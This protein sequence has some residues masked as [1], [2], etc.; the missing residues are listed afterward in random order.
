[1]AWTSA[2]GVGP[3]HLLGV[4]GGGGGWFGRWAPRGVGSEDQDLPPPR[5]FFQPLWRPP[6]RQKQVA[7]PTNT[8]YTDTNMEPP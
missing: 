6:S 5:F 8:E 7:K 4:W 3:L 1:M 2:P